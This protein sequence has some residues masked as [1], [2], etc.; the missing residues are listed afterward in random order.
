MHYR[1]RL[2]QRFEPPPADDP[3]AAAALMQ[4]LRAHLEHELTR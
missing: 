1:L 2:G 4:A 3:A